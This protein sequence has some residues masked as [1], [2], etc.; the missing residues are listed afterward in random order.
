MTLVIGAS[1]AY[2]F[3]GE[4]RVQK[5]GAVEL[6]DE[7][8]IGPFTV[9]GHDPRHILSWN[10]GEADDFLDCDPSQ[11]VHT[12]TESIT[13]RVVLHFTADASGTSGG[14]TALNV[15][16]PSYDEH[17]ATT[18]SPFPIAELGVGATLRSGANA[19]SGT[20]APAP[21][22]PGAAA[23]FLLTLPAPF[24]V[25]GI[26]QVDV[27]LSGAVQPALGP[28]RTVALG[29]PPPNA[30]LVGQQ[31]FGVSQLFVESTFV[32]LHFGTLAFP[33][34]SCP[35]DDFGNPDVGPDGIPGTSDDLCVPNP[36][37]VYPSSSRIGAGES[38]VFTGWSCPLDDFDNP[39]VGPDG[40]PG[41]SDDLCTPADAGWSASSGIGSVSPAT[42]STTTFT[43]VAVAPGETLTGAVVAQVGGNSGTASVVVTGGGGGET[44]GIRL[45]IERMLRQGLPL[46]EDARAGDS[47]LVVRPTTAHELNESLA[48]MVVGG[49]VL[50]F[51]A[52]ASL[53][54]ELAGAERTI[55][56]VSPIDLGALR[57]E[58]AEAIAAA[59][60]DPND[61]RDVARYLRRNP[62]VGRVTLTLDAS[63]D[64]DLLVGA[65]AYAGSVDA[66]FMDFRTD[67]LLRE[68]QKE[69]VVRKRKQDRRVQVKV[70]LVEADD[71]TNVLP[72]DD[73]LSTKELKRLGKAPSRGGIFQGSGEPGSAQLVVASDGRG[74]E[75][76]TR[77]RISAALYT[78]R[79]GEGTDASAHALA[80]LIG[81]LLFG[82]RHDKSDPL[83]IQ[84]PAPAKAAGAGED[85]YTTS[86]E[87]FS[88]SERTIRR[89]LSHLDRH[90]AASP[91]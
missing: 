77:G 1:D 4:Q 52:R 16:I 78:A 51:D 69:Y 12:L 75:S 32:E 67:L 36:V 19:T 87:D 80:H 55:E 15:V 7:Q 90:W 21:P 35:L 59:K 56:A 46:A 83:S 53:L 38:Q 68:F 6:A 17:P 43:A 13:N 71:V 3:S 5:T 41:T 47:Q 27:A 85:F 73:S 50:P 18:N 24:P 2:T 26:V 29:C 82:G 54:G 86:F 65:G 64:R 33:G 81:H 63:L 72:Y 37:V 9:A 58:I 60:R 28:P 25:G 74:R 48:T 42:G 14:V 57:Q 23:S 76:R 31:A 8:P 30:G 34:W 22:P 40:V 10:R 39:D 11:P 89:G 84:H 49:V 61:P 20:L 70:D 44:H 91:R 45:E 79:V 62:E 66:G 88:Y